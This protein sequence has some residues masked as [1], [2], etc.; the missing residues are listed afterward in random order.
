MA[1]R[2]FDFDPGESIHTENSHKY[3][4]ASFEALAAAA[5]WSV[6]RS[7]IGDTPEFGVFMLTN[8]GGDRRRQP[9]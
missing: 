1:G 4:V 3:S 7:W 6:S 2:L 8:P 9:G 5:G